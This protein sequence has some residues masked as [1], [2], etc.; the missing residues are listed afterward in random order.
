MLLRREEPWGDGHT[1]DAVGFGN[2]VCHRVCF[3]RTSIWIVQRLLCGCGLSEDGFDYGCMF[4]SLP[5]TL[6]TRDSI[7]D[8]V[9]EY[10]LEEAQMSFPSGHACAAFALSPVSASCSLVGRTASRATTIVFALFKEARECIHEAP[11]RSPVYAD[12]WARMGENGRG[13]VTGVIVRGLQSEISGRKTRESNEGHKITTCLKHLPMMP[14]VQ[15]FVEH[16]RAHSLRIESCTIS[17]T[18]FPDAWRG[19]FGGYRA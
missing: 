17:Q 19:Q 3:T 4:R 12:H 5:R 9:D 11:R 7:Y 10:L 13:N 6:R 16:I 2:E 1:C 15:E 8:I 14:S 18:A